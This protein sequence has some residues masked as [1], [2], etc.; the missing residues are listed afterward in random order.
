MSCKKCTH[1]PD[2]YCGC[3]CHKRISN[4]SNSDELLHSLAG[5]V[6][7]VAFRDTEDRGD[8]LVLV[9][10]NGQAFVVSSSTNLAFWSEGAAA[11]A[12]RVQRILEPLKRSVR[13]LNRLRYLERLER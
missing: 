5:Q 4:L 10:E 2:T 7:K 1:H 11:V 3:A 6:V 12:K 8:K 13:E 9:M